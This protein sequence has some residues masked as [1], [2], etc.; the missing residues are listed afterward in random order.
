MI[1][2]N[3]GSRFIIEELTPDQRKYINNKVIRR[4]FIFCVFFMATKDLCA[5]LVLTLMF[6]LFV[7]H[8]FTG[9]QSNDDKVDTEKQN[10]L[11]DVQMSLT[12]HL[13]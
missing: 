7:S 4:I 9:N 11:E 8:L 10:I 5:S 3:I 2:I 13:G 1:I 12:K 6:V